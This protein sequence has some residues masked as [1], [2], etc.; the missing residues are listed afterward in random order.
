[1]TMQVKCLITIDLDDKRQINIE[2]A[3]APVEAD[4]I[5]KVSQALVGDVVAK[6]I[7]A[8]NVVRPTLDMAKSPEQIIAAAQEAVASTGSPPSERKPRPA[9]PD[10]MRSFG[11]DD[12][13]DPLA[14]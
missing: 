13:D 7:A 3:A 10:S 11:E 5:D 12:D 1:M 9:D 4:E 8:Y 6:G 14:D 2:S